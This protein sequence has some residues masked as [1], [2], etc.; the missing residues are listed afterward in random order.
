MNFSSRLFVLCKLT[1]DCNQHCKHCVTDAKNGGITNLSA[2][3]FESLLEDIIAIDKEAVL[4]LIGGEATVWPYF[5]DFLNHDLFRSL[6][7]KKLNTNATAM[8]DDQL[9]FIANAGFFEV[10]ISMDSDRALE[11]DL[12]RGTGTFDK[13]I[14]SVKYLTS[15]GAPVTCGTVISKLNYSRTM[16][17]IAL[18]KELGVGVIHFFPYAEKGRGLHQSDLALD[19]YTQKDFLSML[20]SCTSAV[21]RSRNPKCKYGTAYF[22][23]IENGECSIHFAEPDVHGIVLGNIYQDRFATLF[24]KALSTFSLETY[25]C[26]DCFYASDPMMCENMH[27][28]C[29]AD[30]DFRKEKT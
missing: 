7:N 25:D 18:L 15:L 20:S 29:L 4:S 10:R 9:I 22:K 17:L 3:V 28:Y 26:Q 2:E 19:Q 8:N 6:P 12:L 27:N 16:Q 5:Y 23:I 14:H 30:I 24:K 21:S 1:N 11:H 13:T